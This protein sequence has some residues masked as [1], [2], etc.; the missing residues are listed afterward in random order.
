M[1]YPRNVGNSISHTV[2][3]AV[4]L[5]VAFVTKADFNRRFKWKN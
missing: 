4:T 1:Q 2:C 5:A 3:P